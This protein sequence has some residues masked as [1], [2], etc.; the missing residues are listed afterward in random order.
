[1]Q[2]EP[3]AQRQFAVDIVRRL[4]AAGFEALWAGGCVRD[5]LLSHTPK[6]YDVATNATPD[7]VRGVFG[8]RRTLA[9]GASFGVIAVV[10]SR[11][12]GT[13]EV[14]TF[15]QDESYSDGRRPDRVVF[16]NAEQDAQRRDFTINGLFFDPLAERVIDYVGGIVDIGQRRV[17]AIG[18]PLARFTE[19]KLR[20][21][22]A[23]RMAARF[24]FA[25][26]P[27]T[28]EA[29]RGM[30]TEVLVVSAERIA[31]EMRQLLTLPRRVLGLELL[32]NV[33]LLASLLPEV[34]AYRPEAWQQSLRL[35]GELQ[36]QTFP[37]VLGVLLSE[38]IVE[39]EIV[40]LAQVDAV[41][42]RWRLSNEE[43]DQ[44]AW[45]VRQRHALVGADRQPWS[46]V[47]RLFL[48]PCIGALIEWHAARQRL[49]GAVQDDILFCQRRL[50]E[51]IELW[52]PAPLISGDDLIKLGLPGGKR[53]A[54][55]LETVRNAQLDGQVA[56]HSEA[57]VLAQRCWNEQQDAAE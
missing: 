21:L 8:H 14:T 52:N 6:D 56:T 12:Q 24:D 15:R 5:H 49:L 10:G 25:I 7:A 19:D 57:L 32:A 46:R 42:R 11:E 4:R 29:I 53:F 22:R 48:H 41:R 31:Q 9:I 33:K 13:V 39:S 40:T 43:H 35:I 23:V 18:D 54:Q 44:M 20:M 28:A 2:P 34:A 30:A 55:L 38:T 26:D 45:L 17:R 51:P 36:I 50:A 27:T 16:T 1:M 47:Q 3:V 37:L